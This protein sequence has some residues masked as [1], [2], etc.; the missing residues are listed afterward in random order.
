[1]SIQDIGIPIDLSRGTYNNTIYKNDTLQLA[2]L[3]IDADSNV[4][5]TD[6]G[7]WES[8][9]IVIRDKV[10]AFKNVARTVHVSGG[11][12]FKIYVRTSDDGYTWGSYIEVDPNGTIQNTPERYAQIKIEITAEKVNANFFID[13]FDETGKYNNKFV[14]SDKGVLEL[15]K[16]YQYEMKQDTSYQGEGMVLRTQAP[17][18]KF[19][20]ID[21]MSLII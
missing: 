4:V 1:M 18:S 15:K 12:S 2:E 14:N 16:N 17:N 13:K 11:A 7:F 19:Q 9:P 20:K 10:T 8:E 3:G 5:Y 21:R 6:N